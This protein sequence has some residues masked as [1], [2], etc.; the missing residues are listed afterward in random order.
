[1]D[2]NPD[3]QYSEDLIDWYNNVFWLFD[4]ASIPEGLPKL[5]GVDTLWYVSQLSKGVKNALS[6]SKSSSLQDVLTQAISF[7]LEQLKNKNV[8]P[9]SDCIMPSST[10]VLV[11]IQDHLLEYL[12]LGDSFL[13]AREN[14]TSHCISDH[15]LKNIAKDIR[16]DIRSTLLMGKG[17]DSDE[18]KVLRRKLVRSE[19]KARNTENGYWIVSEKIEAVNHAITGCIPLDPE[20]QV[21][22]F[23]LMSDGFA[24]A[25][26]TLDI[27][28]SWDDLQVFVEN[29]GLT[30]VVQLIREKENADYN[31]QKFP[32]TSRHD[33]ASAL[34]VEVQF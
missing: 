5:E 8:K 30:K 15:R 14:K 12:V 33:D 32:R 2:H 13:L 27:F 29:E 28:P 26:T 7:V 18:L 1:M 19:M 6:I 17:Y 10:V 21:H 16:N 9:S 4:G 31:G 34:L 3:K 24:R 20:S 25:V 23:M 22:R 11:R